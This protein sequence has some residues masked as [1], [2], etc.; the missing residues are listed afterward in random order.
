MVDYD[1][2]VVGAGPAGG[3]CTRALTAAGKK[4][5]LLERAPDFSAND[6]SSG[7]APIEVMEQFQLPMSVVGSLWKRFF[8]SS[9]K[10]EYCWEESE[11][12]G[13]VFDFCA[14]RTFL[15]SCASDCLMH[16]PYQSHDIVGNEVQVAFKQGRARCRV[17]VDATGTERKVL[18]SSGARHM[19]AAGV[20]H[21]IE[22]DS[23]TFSRYQEQLSFFL[24]QH[25]M[26][27]GYGWIFPMQEPLLKVG[28][29]RYFVGR[30]YMDYETS[31]LHYLDQLLVRCT[32]SSDHPIIDKHGKTIRYSYGR[33]DK[34]VKGPIIAVGDAVSTIN[35]IGG[36]G[37]RH[38]MLSGQVA[39]EH[40]IRY[41]DGQ[42]QALEEYPAALHRYTRCRWWASERLMHELYGQAND[43]RVD[44]FIKTLTEMSFPAIK[45]LLFHYRYGAFMRFAWRYLKGYLR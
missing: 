43:A 28:V 19:V 35:P 8:V 31:F 16:S 30:H 18:G 41:L 23:S 14:L 15:A 12:Q 29:A 33:R 25:W 10:V 9:S 34:H 21:L 36:E 7:G 17:L 11:C 27:Q 45:D 1:V 13:V 26:P 24:G 38:G 3:Q 20:E 4:V 42:S 6:F 22:V 44:Y 40:V 5:L 37:I 39:A 32:G 2:I